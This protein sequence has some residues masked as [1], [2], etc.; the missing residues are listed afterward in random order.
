MKVKNPESVE[1][2]KIE[3]FEKDNHIVLDTIYKCFLNKENGG[4][5]LKNIFIYNF[6][7]NLFSDIDCFFGIDK[8]KNFDLKFQ[9]N[10]YKNRIPKNMI[11]IAEDCVTNL[12]LLSVKGDDYG[13]VYY[14]DHEMEANNGEEADYSNLTFLANSFGEFI[15]N[16]KSEDDLDN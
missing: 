15:D 2:S 3:N 12:I 14:W 9:N 10:F 4:E 6:K 8:D 11:A 1:I 5:P 7:K 16:L 13:K